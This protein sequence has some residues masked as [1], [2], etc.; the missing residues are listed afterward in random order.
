LK[1]RLDDDVCVA[2]DVG[3]DEIDEVAD[4][5]EVGASHHVKST[6]ALPDVTV[7]SWVEVPAYG[8]YVLAVQPETSLSTP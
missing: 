4:E 1:A 7:M 2:E 6:M 3:V 5:D 8:Q